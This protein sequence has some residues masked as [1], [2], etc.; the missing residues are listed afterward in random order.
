LALA[1]VAYALPRN[2]PRTTV[3]ARAGGAAAAKHTPASM[4]S[5]SKR[6]MAGVTRL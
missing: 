1:N 5:V 2:D 3:A 4:A 6:L